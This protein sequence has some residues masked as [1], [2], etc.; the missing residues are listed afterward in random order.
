MQY[1][2]FYSVYPYIRL[3]GAKLNE[4]LSSTPDYSNVFLQDFLF[5]GGGG[6]HCLHCI[7]IYTHA[8]ICTKLRFA[9]KDSLI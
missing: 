1:L 9:P 8:F 7:R 6:H 2:F 3:L 4:K 5:G